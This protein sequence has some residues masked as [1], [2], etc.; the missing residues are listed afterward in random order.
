MPIQPRPEEL[1]R[2]WLMSDA[3]ND[4]VLEDALARLPERSALVFRHYHLGSV[5]RRER[6]EMLRSICRSKG[7]RLIL[8][9]R[10]SEAR[11]WGADGVY[12][13]PGRLGDAADMLRITTAHDAAELAAAGA[14][15]AHAVMIS[16]VFATRSHPGAPAL[17]PE[18]FHDL[19]RRTSLP[20]IALGGMTAERARDLGVVRWAAI[21]GLS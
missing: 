13:P 15:E 2:L 3:R 20:V 1:P 10:A 12:G 6:F 9:D 7:L 8:S 4:V 14:A 21:D 18:G 5:A 16:P 11:A 19:A 17:G